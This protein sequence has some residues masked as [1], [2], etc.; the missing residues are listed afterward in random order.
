[1]HCWADFTEIPFTYATRHL[2]LLCVILRPKRVAK[3]IAAAARR[4]VM[5]THEHSCSYVIVRKTA[6][7]KAT[8]S[9]K[10]AIDIYP[11]K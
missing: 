3:V 5:E 1:M 7:N 10:T 11:S 4:Q 9:S 6:V 2:L 8:A